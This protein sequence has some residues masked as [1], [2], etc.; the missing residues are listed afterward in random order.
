MI[1]LVRGIYRLRSGKM[2]TVFETIAPLF[3]AA[4]PAQRTDLMGHDLYLPSLYLPSDDYG[5]DGRLLSMVQSGAVVVSAT[6]LPAPLPAVP[7]STFTGGADHQALCSRSEAWL[8]AEGYGWTVER[9]GQIRP[10][11]ADV[12]SAD[13][14]ILVECGNTREGKVQAYLARGRAVL[15][16]PHAMGG[17]CGMGFLLRNASH[18]IG[19][20]CRD[21]AL[22]AIAPMLPSAG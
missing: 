7:L 17:L 18:E 15:L 2:G 21:A 14:V 3:D 1:D 9:L 8:A 6:V 5:K 22:A 20:V 19:P 4:T 12:A 11:A 10:F 16:A 13:H